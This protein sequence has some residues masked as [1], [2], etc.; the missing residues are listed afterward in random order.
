LDA[1]DRLRPTPDRQ[2]QLDRTR[3][4]AVIV[5]GSLATFIG[6]EGVDR[7]AAIVRRLVSVLATPS[8]RV[9]A[10]VAQCLAGLMPAYGDSAEPLAATMI[11]RLVEGATYAERR[12]AAY[13]IAGIAKGRGILSLRQFGIMPA[14][15][16]AIQVR[17]GGEGA[18]RT[19]GEGGIGGAIVAA[20]RPWP[21]G[22]RTARCRGTARARSWRWRRCAHSWGASSSRTWSSC[23]RTC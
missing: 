5:L 15:M 18:A 21:A 19:Q 7:A 20:A 11:E 9:Q 10:A 12:G 4:A 13:G 14:L 8:E 16:E 23:C 1:A 6:A 3:E 2:R 22:C 17:G